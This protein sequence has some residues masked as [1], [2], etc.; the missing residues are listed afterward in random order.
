MQRRQLFVQK[1]L[2]T[3]MRVS[4]SEF[5]LQTVKMHNETKRSSEII[6]IGILS[7]AI[8]NCLDKKYIQY[9]GDWISLCI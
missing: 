6:I 2:K 5:M 8:D 9:F 3:R 4:F 7:L 1:R